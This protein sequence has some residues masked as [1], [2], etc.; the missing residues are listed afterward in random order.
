[1]FLLK[2]RT[3]FKANLVFFKTQTLI[4]LKGPS[5][6]KR[7]ID[8]KNAAAM[9]ISFLQEVF[10]CPNTFTKN[11][12]QYCCYKCYNAFK[13]MNFVMDPNVCQKHKK[14]I[15]SDQNEKA[16]ANSLCALTKNIIRKDCFQVKSNLL[17][18][19]NLVFHF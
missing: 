12:T 4:N 18:V 9:A 19:D 11:Y 17:T 14:L 2:K 6:L 5:A 1:M 10:E 15:N 8:F 13:T 3:F 16:R 7:L